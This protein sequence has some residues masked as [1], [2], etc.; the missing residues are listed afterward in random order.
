M[1]LLFAF[2]GP[3]LWAA[4]THIDKYLVDRYFRNADTTVLIVFT[5]LIGLV[6]L[7]FIAILQP[8]S[9]WLDRTGA[10]VMTASGILYMTAMLFYLR[11]IQSEEASVVAPL[12]Q[13]STIFTF[14]LGY[15]LLKETLTWAKAAGVV[16]I[17]AGAILLAGDRRH[18]AGPF[19]KRL[20]VLMLVATFVVALSSVLFKLFAIRSDY[21]STTFWTFAGEALFGAGILA[22]P[23]YRRQFFDL[24]KT[25][26]NALLAINGANELINLGGGLG[27]R[28]ASLL[29]PVA[30]V[31]AVSS[32][33]T[34]FVFG[35]GILLSMIAPRIAREDLSTGNLV[36]KG[37]AAIMVAAGVTMVAV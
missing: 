11:A 21:W 36:S 24:L 13:A 4:S 6:I 15:L 28:F 37:F 23:R 7:P 12:F 34:L 25:N 22:I 8:H 26:T 31:S 30:L 3:V 1:W 5:A 33:T 10:L 9:L 32:T 19:K 27:V 35:F 29:A 14:I 16:L 20:L 2:S 18:H 17:V